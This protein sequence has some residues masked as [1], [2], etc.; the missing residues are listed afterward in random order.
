MIS[1]ALEYS[2][3][4][5]TV[6]SRVEVGS[7][8]VSVMLDP[9]RSEDECSMFVLESGESVV[10]GSVATLYTAEG[11]ADRS[12]CNFELESVVREAG[13]VRLLVEGVPVLEVDDAAAANSE[14]TSVDQICVDPSLVAISSTKTTVP[15]PSIAVIVVGHGL[16]AAPEGL[17]PVDSEVLSGETL[18]V[19]AGVHVSAP[20]GQIGRV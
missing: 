2:M 6:S 16:A 12:D 5:G 10:E 20:R 7:V 18:V 11:L 1:E 14:A 17:A 3:E 19:V 15:V 4:P 13:K 8:K 9:K